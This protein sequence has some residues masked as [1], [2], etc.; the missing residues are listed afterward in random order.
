MGFLASGSLDDIRLPFFKKLFPQDLPAASHPVDTPFAD[1]KQR[2]VQQQGGFFHNL[3]R[4][5]CND[6]KMAAGK[7]RSKSCPDAVSRTTYL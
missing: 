3:R 5:I 1:T 4:R 7:A 2:S 6:G